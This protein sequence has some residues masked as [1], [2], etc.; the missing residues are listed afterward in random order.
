MRICVLVAGVN[1][2][3]SNVLGSRSIALPVMLQQ[4]CEGETR[5]N[6]YW[7]F[8][9]WDIPFISHFNVCIKVVAVNRNLKS[10]RVG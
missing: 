1:G 10:N 2:K 5:W 8:Y 7:D 9:F 3:F 4:I 6:K